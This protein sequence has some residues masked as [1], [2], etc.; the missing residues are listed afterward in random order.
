VAERQRRA[1]WGLQDC[2]GRAAEQL[3]EGSWAGAASSTR[4]E[5]SS[6]AP[7][8]VAS[9]SR[10]FTRV[11]QATSRANGRLTAARW[12]S[13]RVLGFVPWWAVAG[14]KVLDGMLLSS[15]PVWEFGKPRPKTKFTSVLSVLE[16]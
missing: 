10:S 12:S 6:G 3:S 11:D 9:R 1:N 7:K 5:Q 14:L 4:F 16:D 13:T 15:V 2:G 8:R